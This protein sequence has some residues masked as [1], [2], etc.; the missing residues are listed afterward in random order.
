MANSR[1]PMF[2]SLMIA[3]CV[4]ATAQAQ[5]GVDSYPSKP[6][7]IVIPYVPGGSSDVEARL[8]TQKITESLHQ[9][10]IFDYKPGAGATIGTAFVAKAAPDGYTL[11]MT[12]AS[13]TV[14]PALMMDKSP[15]DPIK[16]F[17]PISITT[18]TPDLLLVKAALPVK[19]VAEYIAYAKANPFKLNFAT[20][21]AGGINHLAG[22]WLHSTTNTMAT[23]IH[24]KGGADVMRSLVSGEADSGVTPPLTAIPHIKSGKVRV[25]GVTTSERVKF[26]PEYPTVIEEGVPGYE[27][28]QWVAV[29]APGKTP[30]AIVNK[31]GA[32]F[33]KAAKLPD[34]IQKL[35]QG[36]LVVGSTPEQLRRLVAREVLAWRKVVQDTGI[37]LE[38]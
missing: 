36:K 26:M 33:G 37:K 22:A 2:G 18:L 15:Y 31:L 14:A 8:Y 32:E 4:S 35:E 21:G 19:S 25:L 29:F 9:P 6:V 38:D 23:Y 5:S 3:L 27:W 7:T 11:L 10:F 17:A 16:D 24:Y 1:I 13:F 20:S 28:S 34:V 30:P 12:T